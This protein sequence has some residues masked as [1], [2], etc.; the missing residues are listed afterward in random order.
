MDISLNITNSIE[1]SLKLFVSYE[2]L[3]GENAYNHDE[4]GK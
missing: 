2:L 3:E 1:E 4:L